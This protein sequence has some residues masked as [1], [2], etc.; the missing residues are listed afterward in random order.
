MQRRRKMYI[1]TLDDKYGDWLRQ[2]VKE[3]TYESMSQ[4]VRFLIREAME[5]EKKGGS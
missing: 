5:K 2:K 1:F 3:D 4:A